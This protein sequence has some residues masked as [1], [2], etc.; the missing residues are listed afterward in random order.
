MLLVL[1]K[2]NETSNAKHINVGIYSNGEISAR[3]L[4]MKNS[5]E[6]IDQTVLKTMKRQNVVGE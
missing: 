2:P 3:C 1:E 5:S 4:I 6:E